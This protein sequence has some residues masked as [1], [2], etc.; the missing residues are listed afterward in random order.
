[1]AFSSKNG[2]LV[3]SGSSALLWAL[4]KL[5]MFLA[6]RSFSLFILLSVANVTLAGGLGKSSELSSRDSI[7][8]A[9]GC[10]AAVVSVYSSFQPKA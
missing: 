2:N 3:V 10:L 6:L 1:M 8:A 5:T 4:Q 9:Q 7:Q